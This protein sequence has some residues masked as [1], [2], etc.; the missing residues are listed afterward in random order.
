MQIA[1]WL[2][3][4]VLALAVLI[5]SSSLFVENADKMSRALQINK[6][7]IGVTVL[8]IGTSLPELM[9]GILASAQGFTSVVPANVFGSNIVNVLLILGIGAYIAKNI[10]LKDEG[11]KGQT[12]LLLGVSTLLIILSYDGIFTRMEALVMIAVYVVY[13]L[14]AISE[15]RAGRF[16]ILKNWL[17]QEKW[18]AK[19]LL[20]LIGTGLLVTASA[21]LTMH[22]LT[23]ISELT[24]ILPSM[25]GASIL[26][27]G[28][29]LPE[30]TVTLS[31]LKKGQT[32]MAVG[33][34]IGSNIFNATLVMA[35]PAL[36]APLN[37]TSDT[38]ILGVPFLLI[39]LILF[40]F[41][42]LKEKL[43]AFDGILFLIIYLTFLG[44]LFNIF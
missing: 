43:S 7:F 18:T 2:I 9:S 42:I 20:M 34:I 29:S 28:T 11:F 14:F 25:L 31:A 23:E 16:D 27:L 21:F 12:G 5:K 4:F 40:A 19:N 17:S 37:V 8:A 22:S 38:L 33:N 24:K 35:I 39:S 1:L 41:A 15:H 32:Q 44:Q 6:L 10:S 13:G 26:A 36:I 30:L 3:I